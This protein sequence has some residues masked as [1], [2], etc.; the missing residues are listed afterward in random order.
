MIWENRRTPTGWTGRW[1]SPG[2][3][4][5]DALTRQLAVARDIRRDDQRRR[6]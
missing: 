2:L 1:K 5:D 6:W 4:L 3:S